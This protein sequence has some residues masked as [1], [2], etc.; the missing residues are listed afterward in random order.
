M[1][2]VPGAVVGRL[3]VLAPAEP[4]LS[5]SG[6]MRRRWRCRCSC[7]RESLVLD[8]SLQVAIRR[9]VGGSR[10]C[11]CLVKETATRHGCASGRRPSPEYLAWLSAKKRCC[12]PANPSFR[13]YG[14]RGITMCARWSRS[15]EAFL[16]DMGSRPGPGFSLDRIDS[17]CGY[18][19]DNC[20][21]ADTETQARNRKAVRLYEFENTTGILGDW[22]AFFGIK[23]DRLRTLIRRGLIPLIEVPRERI[24]PW[25]LTARPVLDLNDPDLVA[26]PDENSR[27]TAA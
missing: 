18:E 21:W 13:H 8:Q 14:A 12:N 10:S 23:R 3:T 2:L 22:A 16:H 5:R 27:E 11:G 20:R 15:F 4:L 7:G 25:R 6:R 19:P 9:P 26:P 1:T 24:D 17:E